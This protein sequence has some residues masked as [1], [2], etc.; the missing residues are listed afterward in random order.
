[1]RI[2]DYES[3]KNLTD[4]G[5]SL[6]PDEAEELYIYLRKMLGNS[7]LRKAYLTELNGCGI[8]RELSVTIERDRHRLPMSA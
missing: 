1:M 4:V 3:R 2:T 7:E 5:L 8:G 6:T